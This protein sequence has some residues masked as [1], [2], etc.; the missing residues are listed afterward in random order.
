MPRPTQ[1]NRLHDVTDTSTLSASDKHGQHTAISAPIAGH[2]R[3]HHHAGRVREAS[4]DERRSRARSIAA[5]HRLA[6]LL[7]ALDA[8]AATGS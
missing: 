6:T 1:R 5:L 4:I 8:V 7:A 2:A 3:R